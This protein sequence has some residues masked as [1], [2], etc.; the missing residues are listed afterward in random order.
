MAAWVKEHQR[1]LPEQYYNSSGAEHHLL[2]KLSAFPRG[3]QTTS[4][5]G[6]YNIPMIFDL[7]VLICFV[8]WSSAIFHSSKPMLSHPLFFIII[9]IIIIFFFFFFFFFCF[10]R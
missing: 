7:F 1:C 5:M 6:V 4:G 9:I 2:D 10:R 8:F 3:A